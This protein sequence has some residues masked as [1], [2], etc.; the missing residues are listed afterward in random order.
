MD[1]RSCIWTVDLAYLFQKLSIRFS[2]FTVILGANPDF[3]ME[4]FYKE[5]LANDICKV[6]MLFQRSVEE[7]IKIESTLE[8]GCSYCNMGVIYKNR[9]DLE[10][11][12]ACYERCLAVSP[13]RPQEDPLLQQ[14]AQHNAH[15]SQ[16][17]ISQNVDQILLKATA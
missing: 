13:T 11:A 10:S 16:A 9:G 1:H 4:K 6:D 3:S 7:G 14:V 2:F 8:G 17:V 12:I 5:Q 15:M